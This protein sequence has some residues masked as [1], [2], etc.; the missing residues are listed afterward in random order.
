MESL[1]FSLWT[2]DCDVLRYIY[3]IFTDTDTFIKLHT[4]WDYKGNSF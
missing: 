4:T 3:M 2:F 1:L